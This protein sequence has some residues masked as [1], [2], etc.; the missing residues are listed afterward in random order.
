M[1]PSIKIRHKHNRPISQLCFGTVQLGI[2]YGIA[3]RTGMPDE[4]ISQELL[5]VAGDAGITLFDTARAYGESERRVGDALRERDSERITIMTKLSPLEDCTDP[6]AEAKVRESIE[7]SLR[8]LGI[9]SLPYVL[10][11]RAAHLHAYSGAIWREL[12]AFKKKGLVGKLGVSVATPQETLEALSIPEVECLQLPYNILDWRWERSGIPEAL[13]KRPNVLVLTRSAL[14]QGLLTQDSAW[15]VIPETQAAEVIHLLNG[16]VKEFGRRH[17][18]DL[19]LAFVRG[20][21]WIDSVVVGMETM[22]QLQENIA[23]FQTPPL[24][25]EECTA[26]RARLPELREALLNPALWPKRPMPL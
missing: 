14:L 23:M 22:A 16:W 20:Q 6:S 9:A 26:I 13:A 15:P 24:S 25:M 19:C 7:T 17:R 12:L 4:H 11:H 10:L 5:R 2:P 21:G 8:N 3:N 18:A 1:T